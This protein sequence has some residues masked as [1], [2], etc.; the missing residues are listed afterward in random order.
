MWHY[1]LYCRFYYCFGTGGH[2]RE[3]WEIEWLG[4]RTGQLERLLQGPND[5]SCGQ[6]EA[7]P[8]R[9]TQAHHEAPDARA[10][11]LLCYYTDIIDRLILY[12]PPVVSADLQMQCSS[13]TR[14]FIIISASNTAVCDCWQTDFLLTCSFLILQSPSYV[15]IYFISTSSSGFFFFFVYFSFVKRRAIWN[16]VII[17]YA[18]DNQQ[19]TKLNI[20]YLY[21]GYRE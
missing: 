18:V 8:I 17:P 15:C 9:T 2:L 1:N 14:T 19:K 6:P 20:I 4:V 12:Q 7:S 16:V 13:S 5:G 11:S 3:V 10:P 21:Y